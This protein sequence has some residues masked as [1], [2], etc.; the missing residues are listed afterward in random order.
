MKKTIIIS[1]LVALLL[2]AVTATGA[3]LINGSKLKDH[4]VYS[5]KLSKG[6]N[7][8]RAQTAARLA[9]LEKKAGIP[10]PAGTNGKNGTDGKNGTNGSNG[11]NGLPGATG[12]TGPAG[13][14]GAP[15]ANGHDGGLP[16]GVFVTNKSVGLTKSGVV[17]GPYADGGSAGGS[18]YYNGLNGKKLRDITQLAAKVVHSSDDHSPIGIPYVRVFLN[19]D[20]DDLV[21]DQTNCATN[22]PAENTVNTISI[23]STNTRYDDDACGAS[24]ETKSFGEQV[25]AHGDDVISGIYVTTGFTGGTNLTATLKELAVNGR[26]FAFGG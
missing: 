15:G 8:E 4:T 10:G 14:P 19:D 1:A 9:A 24:A 3:S 6:L 18:V 11:A 23:D 12:S 20:N 13:T 21:L 26:T 16:Q 22:V 2:T 17:F 25:E 7:A 5:A